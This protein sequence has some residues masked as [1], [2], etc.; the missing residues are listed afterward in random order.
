MLDLDVEHFGTALASGRRAAFVA[1][2]NTRALVASEPA[3]APLARAISEM[4]D[5]D[6]HEAMFFELDERSGALFTVFLHKTIRGQGAGGVR[7]WSYATLGDVVRD[8]LRL[9]RGMGRKNALAGLFWGGGK[10]VIASPKGAPIADPEYRGALYRDYGRFVTSLAGAY[11]TAEDVGTMP[12]DMAEI[13]RTTRFVTCIPRAAGGSGNP[14]HATAKGVVCAMEAALEQRGM[15]TL[16]GKRVGLQGVGNVGG[17]MI[18]ELFDRGVAHVE[19]VDTNAGNVSAVARRFTDK[20]LQVRV[21]A[22]ADLSIFETPCDVF[23]PNALGAILNPRTIP[24]LACKVVCGAA[25]NQLE[26]E[27]RDDKALR[28]RSI[29]YVPDFVANRM[30]IVSCANEQ[31]GSIEPDPAIERHFSRDWDGGIFAITRRVLADAD[32]RGVT[33]S[34]AAAALADALSLVPHPIF[35]HRARHI[36]ESLSTSRWHSHAESSD[37]SR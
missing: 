11:V 16:A 32:R 29:T 18:G 6:E 9:S 13:F 35:P 30:G 26:D 10:G 25:N 17:S 1:L 2:P 8:G 19:A 22:P 5:F 36:V 23:A 14:S 15:G 24:L 34:D 31:Y 27:R 20:S 4:S 37:E 33:T 21:V 3:L 7:H 12:D 28:E